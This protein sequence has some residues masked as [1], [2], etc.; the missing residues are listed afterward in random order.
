MTNLRETGV[1]DIHW[2]MPVPECGQ[3][4]MGWQ[5][6]GA[7]ILSTQWFKS[8][9][10]KKGRRSRDLS[11]N[12]LNV[13]VQEGRG[14]AASVDHARFRISSHDCEPPSLLQRLGPAVPESSARNES[15]SVG[16]VHG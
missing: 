7:C 6:T 8:D 5:L 2:A 9:W 15:L 12:R 1:L 13:T 16:A 14:S 4:S 10:R 11:A 3:L